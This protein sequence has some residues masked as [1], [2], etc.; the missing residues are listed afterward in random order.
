MPPLIIKPEEVDEVLDA[1]D[2]S[3]GEVAQ[4]LRLA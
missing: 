1:L 4:S 3:L 2:I